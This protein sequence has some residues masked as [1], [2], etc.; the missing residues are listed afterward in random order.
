MSNVA[1]NG[2]ARTDFGGIWRIL[3]DES[4]PYP[5]RTETVARMVAACT[6]TT[7]LVLVFRLPDAFL[8]VFYAFVISRERPEWLVRNGFAAVTAS[9][10][11]VVYVAAGVQL[12]YDYEVLHFAFLAFTLYLVFYLR[13]ALTNDGVTFGFGV[14]ATV[15][16]T[17]IWDQPNPTEAHL[18]STLSLSFVV[19]LGTLVAMAVAWV[20][21]Q[22]K[23]APGAPADCSRPPLF[24]PDAFSNREYS[25]YAFKGCVAG[26]L[27][28]ILD[29]GVAWPV[30]MGACAETCIVAAR[31]L[32]AGAGT[33]SERL[34]VSVTAIIMGGIVLGFGSQGLL[35]PFVDSITGFILQFVA[36][37]ALV[38]WVA[39]SS[40]RLSYAGTLGAMGFF[41]P[42]VTG[43]A[44]N[45]PLA[46]SGAFLVDLVLA[47]VA[48]WLV[49]DGA[50]DSAVEPESTQYA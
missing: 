4:R 23:A 36:I 41:F 48:F 44:P 7:L 46:R 30:I 17:L 1:G 15:A 5:G 18:D 9:A 37:A 2:G 32:P 38:A 40:P 39:T 42:M 47:L 6:I 21:L 14:T 33:R 12:F 24:V 27:C 11:A 25:A 20:A 49:L 26:L 19:A 3:S 43:F 8:G 16:L 45:P 31:P 28:Y 10:A 22:L 13:R 29:S 35:L 34:F 50:S